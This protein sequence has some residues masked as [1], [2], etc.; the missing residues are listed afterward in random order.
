MFYQLW[1]HM[2]ETSWIGL[3]QGVKWW[4]WPKIIH[5]GC[6]RVIFLEKLK[7]TEEHE[8]AQNIT[9]VLLFYQLWWYISETSWI[10]LIQGVKWWIWPK[11]IHFDRIRVIFLVKLKINRSTSIC[12][13]YNLSTSLLSTLMTYAKNILN[14]PDPGG[15]MM[16]MYQNY[17][18]SLHKGNFPGKTKSNRRI[19]ICLKYNLGTSLLSTLMT[20]FKNI[21]NWPDPG[22]QMMDMTQNCSLLG[23]KGNFPGISKNNKSTKICLKYG[24]RCAGASILERCL[25]NDRLS[26]KTMVQKKSESENLSPATYKCCWE[27]RRCKGNINCYYMTN[28]YRPGIKKFDWFK[29]GL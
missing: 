20:Y 24:L 16:D 13:K 4:I 3:I 19:W 22:G 14:W 6:I 26:P 17:S 23:H 8:Y 18:F 28:S 11:I 1:W 7:T 2:S 21:L 25:K 9:W 5:F 15:Q 12:S 27:K 29:A 10:G